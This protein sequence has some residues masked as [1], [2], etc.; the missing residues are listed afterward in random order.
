[1]LKVENVKCGKIVYNSNSTRYVIDQIILDAAGVNTILIKNLQNK[2][3]QP[4]PVT[5]NLF[6]ILWETPVVTIPIDEYQ[7][8]V[9]RAKDAPAIEAPAAEENNVVD[10][11]AEKENEGAKDSE[12]VDEPK[13]PE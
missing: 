1:M 8:L 7:S 11:N 5:K 6:N 13:K 2:Q 9:T 12:T 3:E 10:F 4:M